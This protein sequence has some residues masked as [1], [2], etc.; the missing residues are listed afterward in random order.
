MVVY[1]HAMVVYLHAMVVYV[2][3]IVSTMCGTVFSRK[4]TRETFINLELYICIT[5]SRSCYTD[6]GRILHTHTH[7]QTQTHTFSHSLALF[8]PPSDIATGDP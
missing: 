8:L 3:N 2:S 7:T 5:L 6:F 4:H 1:L